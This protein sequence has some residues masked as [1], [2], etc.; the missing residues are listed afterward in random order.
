IDYTTEGCTSHAGCGRGSSLTFGKTSNIVL[1]FEVPIRP[2]T[3]YLNM[4][5]FPLVPALLS[6]IGLCSCSSIPPEDAKTKLSQR[7]A[8]QERTAE[9]IRDLP[10]QLEVTKGAESPDKFSRQR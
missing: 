9:A 8:E 5:S 10:I 7:R 1:R 4:K 2:Q 3:T 6:C